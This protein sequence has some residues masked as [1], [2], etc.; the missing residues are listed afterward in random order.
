MDGERW[1]NEDEAR[2]W[3]AFVALSAGVKGKIDGQLKESSGM[4]IGDYEVLVHLSEAPGHRLRM[5]VLST[6]TMHARS[7][8]S[9]RIDRMSKR[10]LIRRERALEDGRGMVAVITDLGLAA[11]E[12]AAPQH[13]EHVRQHFVDLIDPELLPTLYDV[14]YRIASHSLSDDALADL[15]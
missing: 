7:Q 8:L 12:E 2:V 15:E 14:F 10:G 6:K 5:H 13:V 9:Q 4:A 11:I 3:R 1:L